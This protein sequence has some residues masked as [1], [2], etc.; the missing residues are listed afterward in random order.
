M[1]QS[2]PR[3]QPCGTPLEI[4]KFFHWCFA[5]KAIFYPA[6]YFDTNTMSF[7]LTIFQVGLYQTPHENLNRW[8]QILF[9]HPSYYLLH[10]KKIQIIGETEFVTT[11]N[12]LNKV[13]I[14]GLLLMK[15][16]SVLLYHYIHKLI[17]NNTVHNYFPENTG[18]GY[19]WTVE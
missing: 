4:R 19:Y 5:S 10:Y 13:I 2:G 9:L 18:Q 8:N 7:Y 14:S 3:T 12:I 11:E 1:N 17:S 6:V 15:P 16:Y